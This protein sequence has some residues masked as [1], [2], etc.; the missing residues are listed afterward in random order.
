VRI[1][2]DRTGRTVEAGIAPEDVA[3]LAGRQP[4]DLESQE[5]ARRLTPFGIVPARRRD[6]LPEVA[7][8][9]LARWAVGLRTPSDARRAT[10]QRFGSL[11]G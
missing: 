3:V 8:V 5:I 2:A 1:D 11:L 6:R 7:V 9:A 10:E 4:R